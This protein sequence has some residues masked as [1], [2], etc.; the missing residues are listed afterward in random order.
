MN[1]MN[2]F[3]YGT[4][5]F[6]DVW[7]ALIKN[8]YHKINARLEGY[9]RLEVNGEVYPGV[10][11]AKESDVDGVLMLGVRGV[12]MLVLDRFEGEFYRRSQVVVSAK[13]GGVHQAQA[14]IFRHKYRYMLGDAEWDVDKFKKS[15]IE[16]FLAEYGGFR[17]SQSQ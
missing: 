7:V 10:I 8:R 17:E 2:V 14:Y 11:K 4:L 9:K 16:V 5:M 13:D 1:R 3:V 15:G 12:D 6:D